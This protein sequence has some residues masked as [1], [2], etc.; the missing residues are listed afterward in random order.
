[1]FGSLWL[2]LILSDWHVL[3]LEDMQAKVLQIA[4]DA[5]VELGKVDGGEGENA[6]KLTELTNTR[7]DGAADRVARQIQA[8]LEERSSWYIR[9]RRW[10]KYIGRR[11]R[12]KR[13]QWEE[14]TV[15]EGLAKY[16]RMVQEHQ[17]DMQL[18]AEGPSSS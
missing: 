7:A 11:A 18:A 1:M 14:A 17:T 16:A 15:D 12:D 13:L 2:R 5:L 6:K 3:Y 8:E 9:Q 4:I 10:K